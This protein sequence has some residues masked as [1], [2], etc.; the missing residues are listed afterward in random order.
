MGEQIALCLAL[1]KNVIE[2][3]YECFVLVSMFIYLFTYILTYLFTYLLVYI[4]YF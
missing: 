1:E 3:A 2:M 4:F